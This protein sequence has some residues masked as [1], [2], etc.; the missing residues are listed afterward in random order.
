MTEHFISPEL[1]RSQEF[2]S[3]IVRLL[4]WF[5]MLVL[6]GLAG[7][8][9]V[10]QF[11]WEVFGILFAIHLAWYLAIQAH[12]IYK[13]QLIRGRTYLGVVAD[14]SGTSLSIFL[15]G[16]P[17]S[18]FALLY[19]LSY[20]SQGT[21]FGRN[22]LMVTSIASIVAF[23]IVSTVLDGWRHSPIEL[24]FMLLF[25]VTLPLYQ[26]A[27]LK[28]LQLAKQ[29][30]EAANRARGNFL[31]TMTHE[32]RTPLS[33]VIGMSGLL[34]G[35]RMDEEQKEYL[36]SIN[37]SA[38]VLQSLIGDILDLSKI[39]AGKLELKPVH[40]DVRNALVEVANALGNQAQ[41]KQVE[42]VCRVAPDVPVEVYG[43]D[44]RF[45][46]ILFNLMG[47]AVKFTEEGE[48]CASVSLGRPDEDLPVRHLLVSI[49]DT[50]IGISQSKLA[51]I[52]DSF[53]QA[54]SSTT[55]RYGGTG[56]GTTI[57]RD[58]TRL[59][60]G[61]IGVDSQEGKGSHFWIKVPLVDREVLATPQAPEVLL[62]RR[63]LVLESN[64]ASALAIEEACKTANMQYE[65]VAGIE[66]LNNLRS[67][68]GTEN[69]DLLLVSDSPVGKDL[70]GLASI[71]RSLLGKNVPVVYLH[72]PRHKL[73]LLEANTHSVSKPFSMVNLWHGM[74]SVIRPDDV[75]VAG[76]NNIV[77]NERP[78]E[79]GARILVAEDDTINAKLIR[80]LLS[81]AG[82][83]VTL[84]RDGEAALQ[85]AL[86]D[87]FDLALIDLRM[88]KMDGLDFARAYRE[89]EN[90][91]ERLPIIALTANA[92]ESARADCIAAGMDEFLTKPIDPQMLTGLMRSYGVGG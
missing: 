11:D 53:W 10:Y 12:V 44:L 3:G 64:S 91:G 1:R 49:K 47:N 62:G 25:M 51:D 24:V 5:L 85:A 13:P 72:H 14:M 79:Q 36:E 7:I 33:G 67:K 21:R 19:V 71:M 34:A 61:V 26:Y 17:I 40:F 52:F 92:A 82:H 20:L 30:A 55:R 76:R 77:E 28:K 74:A 60:G 81:K 86:Q 90:S 87:N 2:Q 39:D 42:L 38:N 73:P 69:V 66:E 37:T 58:L 6:L 8:F 57:A 41:E 70:I 75:V 80:S 31:A 59:M 16:N 56:L 4:V 43:D 65:L 15:S 22:N 27:L 50:G 48:V 46:Q 54:D 29:A 35:T 63:V 83:C 32:L 88:P 78:V 89:Q 84:V 23:S 9:G 45:R 18:P 68:W